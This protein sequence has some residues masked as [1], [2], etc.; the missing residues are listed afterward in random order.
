[1][2]GFKP[3]VLTKVA[4]I[5]P[6]RMTNFG[7]GKEPTM[8]RTPPKIPFAGKAPSITPRP[9]SVLSPFGARLDPYYGLRDDSRSDPE[10]LGVL[11]NENDYFDAYLKPLQPLVATL[12]EEFKR[13]IPPNEHSV[14]VWRE[15]RWWQNRYS[16]ELEYPQIVSGTAADES[17]GVVL[18]DPNVER[19]QS[20]FYALGS[21]E[22][23][24]CERWLAVVED[25]TGRRE[26][27]LRVIDRQTNAVI[28]D[29]VCGIEPEVVWLNSHDVLYIR[30]D[31]V[32]LLGNQVYRHTVGSDVSLDT[33]VYEELDPEFT[34]SIQRSRSG[35][36]I[37]IILHQ[38]LTSEIHWAKSDDP[39]LRFEVLLP[40]Q[41]GIEYS[42]EDFEDEVIF[43]INEQ[44]SEFKLV[45]VA[46]DQRQQRDQ[47]REIVGHRAD[48][49]IDDFLCFPQCFVVRERALGQARL[50]RIDARSHA[51][52][53]ISTMAGP[54]TVE[55]GANADAR[56]TVVRWVTS[57]PS[58]SKRVFD[59]HLDR[60]ES[61]CRQHTEVP[62]CDLSRYRTEQRWV[63]ARD[64]QRI[65]VT[66]LTSVQ[67]GSQPVP[68]LLVGYGAYGLSYDPQFRSHWLSLV[69]RHMAV[70]IAHIRGGQELGRA[71]TEAGRRERK[72]NTF[73]DFVDVARAMAQWAEIDGQRLVAMGGSAGGLLMGAVVNQAPECFRAVVAQVP[74]VDVLTT[75]L[76][77]S[78]PLTTNEYDE[79]GNPSE[80]RE[81]YE[82]LLAY[83][84]IDQTSA[85]DYP[86]LLLTTGLYDSQVQYWEPVKWLATLRDVK[87][88]D[89][90]VF[91][92]TDLA[93]GHGGKAGRF[94]RLREIAEEYAF[95]LNEV[96]L[97]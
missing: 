17:D 90:P 71:W 65:P 66:L 27:T 16:A 36:F 7:L 9:A 19:K 69:D 97:G 46:F 87:T 5:A 82:R 37:E 45:R 21:L 86:P 91:L 31:P 64:G 84:P 58:Q 11:R 62:H 42:A 24:P 32:T 54:A 35:R 95:V 12:V 3:L 70:A 4:I 75:M 67:Q 89:H 44:A 80:S 48:V 14:P 34:L 2:Y 77:E 51:V 96:G 52:T 57:S 39:A 93:A 94:E 50:M 43:K 78:L 59:T 72:F 79:W 76:D 1:L 74:F 53:P 56:L 26:Y 68:C 83:S 13:R 30:K 92:R 88:D 28:Q 81:Q 38:T 40:R 6:N 61:V 60:L 15:G 22:L 73:N 55:F 29:G 47:W 25:W 85:Y 20:E 23:S 33:K 41:H 10:I 8:K 49:L 63:T 18:F